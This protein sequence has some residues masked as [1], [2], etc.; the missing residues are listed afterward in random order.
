MLSSMTT[1]DKIGAAIL[2]ALFVLLMGILIATFRRPY[3]PAHKPEE[4]IFIKQR[5]INLQKGKQP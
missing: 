5:I 1:R 2:V 3:G 4:S